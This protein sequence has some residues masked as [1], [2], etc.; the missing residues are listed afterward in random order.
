LTLI[1]IDIQIAYDRSGRR[2]NGACELNY[3]VDYIVN[4]NLR[5]S[6]ERENLIPRE[7]EGRLDL[8]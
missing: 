7:G 3:A 6:T 4:Y 8:F 5:A 1:G 2:H